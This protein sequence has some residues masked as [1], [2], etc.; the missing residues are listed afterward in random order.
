MTVQTVSTTPT[1]K[2]TDK[3]KKGGKDKGGYGKTDMANAALFST[4]NT[5]KL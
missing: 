1:I 3:K 2:E 4:A 5:L